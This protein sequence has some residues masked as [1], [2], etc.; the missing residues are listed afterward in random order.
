MRPFLLLFLFLTSFATAFAQES[1]NTQL[2]GHLPYAE[3]LSEVRGA[4]HNGREYAL[5]GVYN[6]FSIVDVTNPANPTQVFFEPGPE[7]IWRDPFYNDGYAY[8]VT[9]G[10]GGLVI[11]DMSPLPGNTNL[12]VVNY[13]GSTFPWASAH[14]MFIDTIAERAY[15]FGSNNGVGGAIILDVSNPMSPVELGRWD[16]HYIHDAYVRGDT[17]WAACLEAGVFLVDVSD[18]AN[19]VNMSNWLTPSEFAH[20]VWPSDDNAFCFT[21]DEVNSG[22]VAGYNMANLQNVVESDK[23]RHPL[24]TGVIPHNVHYFNG[25]LLTSHYRDGLTIHDATD[26]ENIILSGYYDTSPFEG[27]GFNGAWGTWPYLPSGNVLVADIEEGLFVVGVDYVEAA[28]LEGT[29]TNASNSVPLSDVQVTVV[30]PSLVEATDIFGHYATGLAQGGTF[31]VTFVKGGFLTQTVSGV[32]LQNGQVTQVDVELVPDVA[33][34]FSGTVTEVGTGNAIDGAQVSIVN[35]FFDLQLN[36]NSNGQY[37]QNPFFAGSY[38]VTVGAWGYQTQCQTIQVGV[39]GSA[40]NFELTKGYYDDFALDFEWEVLGDATTGV[41]V[42]DYPIGTDY[43]GSFANPDSDVDDDC[44][45]LAFVT[46]NTEGAVGV[47]DVDDGITILRSPIFDLSDLSHANLTF[48]Y[49]FFNEGGDGNPNDQLIV[50]VNNGSNITTLASLPVTNGWTNFSISLDAFTDLTDSM[51]VYFET[52]D[53]PSGH[54]VE[55]GIDRF[56]I[57]DATGIDEVSAPTMN[58]YPNP[59]NGAATVRLVGPFQK[60]EL[61]VFDS[62]GR[63]VVSNKRM[64]SGNNPLETYLDSGIYFVETVV[65]GQRI[66]AKLVVER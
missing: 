20:N 57:V 59:S 54:L 7:S 50:K 62:M 11:V 1:L 53:T 44:G 65:D 42:R 64:V 47:D 19:P 39:N 35:E 25:F 45:G 55:A 15:I 66:V 33:F 21:T 14:N 8:C 4:Y 16:D 13:T 52:A 36:T 23:V 26:P 30:G 24:T 63:Q 51:R 60:A 22:F 43:N 49:W 58:I 3:D 9:E 56:R 29:V 61:R 46:G 5:V 17:M 12:N 32:V 40:P 28:R 41:W 34:N 27:G 10:G 31:D 18:P 38:E 2:L 37:A 48:D 6:G